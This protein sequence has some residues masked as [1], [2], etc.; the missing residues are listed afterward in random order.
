MATDHTDGEPPSL[1]NTILLNIGWMAKISSA[2]RKSVTVY[3]GSVNRRAGASFGVGENSAVFPIEV[4]LFIRL[5]DLFSRRSYSE[6]TRTPPRFG[7]QGSRHT[8]LVGVQ[9]LIRHN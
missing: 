8:L 6:G 4:I 2:E 1:G 5:H 7:A 3:R 9:I